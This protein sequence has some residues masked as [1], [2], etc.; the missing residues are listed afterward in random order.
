MFSNGF[1]NTK[2]K[3]ACFGCFNLVN[4]NHMEWKKKR[5]ATIH[6]MVDHKNGHLTDLITLK[7]DEILNKN[8]K[9]I[10]QHFKLK[11]IVWQM[12]NIGFHLKLPLTV[13]R[14]KRRYFHFNCN[15]YKNGDVFC[16]SFSKQTWFH[17][18][19]RGDCVAKWRPDSMGKFI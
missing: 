8:E 7:I 10:P 6:G 3:S 13:N 19:D 5:Y 14:R 4:K 17:A 11:S 16:D 15:L 12:C 9:K 2:W 18:F 1:H